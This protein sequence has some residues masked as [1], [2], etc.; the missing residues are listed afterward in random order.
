MAWLR[1]VLG[2]GCARPVERCGTAASRPQASPGKKKGQE[3][4]KWRF[5]PAK[6]QDFKELLI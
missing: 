5:A 1:D 2:P 4:T 3:R 6:K